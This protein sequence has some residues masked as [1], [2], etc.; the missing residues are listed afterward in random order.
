MLAE[1]N[2]LDLAVAAKF[3]RCSR[4]ENASVIDD[5]SAVRDPQGFSDIMVSD[6]NPDLSGF[7][8]INDFLD[9]QD[10]YRIDSRKRLIQKNKFW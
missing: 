3:F 5:I 2:P 6:K 8:V 1:I 4:P 9:L 10:R 7:Q